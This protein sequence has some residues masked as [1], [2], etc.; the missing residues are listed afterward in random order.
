L[1]PYALWALAPQASASANFATSAGGQPHEYI[2]GAVLRDARGGKDLR[3]I[4]LDW[5][6]PARPKNPGGEAVFCA[7]K[8]ILEPTN[9]PDPWELRI[10][11]DRQG[12]AL[13]QAG[14]VGAEKKDHAGDVFGF[15][16]LGKVGVGHGFSVRVGVDDAGQN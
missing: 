11:I 9:N 7:R 12:S 3:G 4:D 15:G 1:N 5:Y 16:P 2:K 13:N 14:F 8:K 6:A 10:A